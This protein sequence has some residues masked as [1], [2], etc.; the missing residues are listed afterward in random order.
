MKN[1]A[2]RYEVSKKGMKTRTYK[3]F[4]E[5]CDRENRKENGV[6]ESF[7]QES[8]DYEKDNHTNI[9]CWN[10]NQCTDC[11]HCKYLTFCQGCEGCSSCISCSSCRDCNNSADCTDCDDCSFCMSCK[12]CKACKGCIGCTECADSS[13]CNNCSKCSDCSD[14][15]YVDGSSSP[16]DVHKNTLFG[17]FWSGVTRL[18]KYDRCNDWD[19]WS[20]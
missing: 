3:T 1:P 4:D 19:H 15:N 2:A 6:S 13:Y 20:D 7:A 16:S 14:Y 10:C 8:P 11:N 17:K 5:F 12:D 18:L 9:G